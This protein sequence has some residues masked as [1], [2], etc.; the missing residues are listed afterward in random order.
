MTEHDWLPS[1]VAPVL[2]IDFRLVF[3]S[4]ERHC[5]QTWAGLTVGDLDVR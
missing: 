5:A 1:G 4:D 2:I 3:R